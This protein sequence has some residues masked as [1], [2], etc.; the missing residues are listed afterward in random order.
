M[1]V[2]FFIIII[3]KLQKGCLG[4]KRE[5]RKK[6]EEEKKSW[7]DIYAYITTRRGAQ[8]EMKIRG[9][10]WKKRKKKEK[11]TLLVRPRL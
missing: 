9:T 6:E 11:K 2:F 5:E 7:L 10:V 8:R 3:T 4:L 1:F